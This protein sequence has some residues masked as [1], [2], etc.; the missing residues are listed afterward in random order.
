MPLV[1]GRHKA[2]HVVMMRTQPAKKRNTPYSMEHIIWLKH[3]PMMKLAMKL[4][5]TVVHM[6]A[7]RVWFVWIS[8][9]TCAHAEEHESPADSADS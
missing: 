5:K 9:G 6:P 1:S 3:C 2:T 4:T 8:D 7:V